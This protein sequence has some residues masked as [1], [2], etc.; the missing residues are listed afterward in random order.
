MVAT[1]EVAR[2]KVTCDVEVLQDGAKR[3]G[4]TCDVEGSNVGSN[5]ERTDKEGSNEDAEEE[6][7]KRCLGC[8][9]LHLLVNPAYFCCSVGVGMALHLKRDHSHCAW[10]ACCFLSVVISVP[11]RYDCCD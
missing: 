1:E 3:G 11:W 6:L 9:A 7:E 8:A 2:N 10:Y 5:V 4:A